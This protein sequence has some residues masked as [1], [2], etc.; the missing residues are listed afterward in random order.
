[1][2]LILLT[3]ALVFSSLAF[4]DYQQTTVRN[5]YGTTPV[6]TTAFVE[7]IHSAANP[8]NW[9][10]VFDSSGQTLGLYTGQVGAEVL[11]A[12]IPPGGDTLPFPCAAG[13]RVSIK[14]LSA[15]ATAGELDIN[16]H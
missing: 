10:I 13:S 12:I 1:M 15:D 16:L 7:L 2:K 3:L 6:T 8:T 4:G 9:A 11:Q 5:V 14:A